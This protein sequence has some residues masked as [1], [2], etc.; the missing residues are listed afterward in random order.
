MVKNDS[1]D[2]FK[3]DSD[4]EEDSSANEKMEKKKEIK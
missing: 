4:D 2:S 1:E 3:T